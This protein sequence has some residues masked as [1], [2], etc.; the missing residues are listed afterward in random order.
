MSNIVIN[1]FAKT[2]K[3]PSGKAQVVQDLETFDDIYEHAPSVNNTYNEFVKKFAKLTGADFILTNIKNRETS[4]NKAKRDYDNRAAF[5]TDVVR[6]KLVANNSETIAK[7]QRVLD[8][9]D[10]FGNGLLVEFDVFCAQVTDYFKDPKHRTKYRC[11]NSKLSFP[12]SGMKEKFLCELQVVDARIES[13]YDLTHWAMREAQNISGKYKYVEVPDKPAKIRTMLYNICQYYNGNAA[14]QSKLDYML[15]NPND[16]LSIEDANI[17]YERIFRFLEKIKAGEY[18]EELLA[19]LNKLDIINKAGF[20]LSAAH[21]GVCMEELD[22][23]RIEKGKAANF[24]C[25]T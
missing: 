23:E 9:N 24:L 3:S 10:P 8:P 21:L 7:I 16:A 5:V 14:R 13:V 4:E 25:E 19:G 17:L 11:L 12:I 2:S 22:N 18:G 20:D 6:G 15:T 1:D